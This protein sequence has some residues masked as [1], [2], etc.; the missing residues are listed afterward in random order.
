MICSSDD[1]YAEIAPEIFDKLKDK[2]IIV[3]AGYPKNIIDELK[4][5]GIQHFVHVKSNVLESLQKFQE[6]LC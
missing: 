3:V 1:E 4:A 6:E 2:A 5:K